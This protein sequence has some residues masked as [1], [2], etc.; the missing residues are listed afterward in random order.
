MKKTIGSLILV[1]IFSFTAFAA[2]PNSGTVQIPAAVKVG[3]TEIPAGSYKVSWTGTGDNAQVTLK[4]GKHTVTTAA[5]VVDEKHPQNGVSTKTENGS[6]VLTQIQFRD[7]T[8]VFHE[9]SATV[10]GQ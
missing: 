2:S 8:L 10:A 4:Q 3:G 1:T 7:K 5:Q 9:T 6:R